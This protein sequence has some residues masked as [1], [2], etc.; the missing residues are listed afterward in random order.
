LLSICNTILNEL[1][2]TSKEKELPKR[3]LKNITVLEMAKSLEGVDPSTAYSGF[4][5]SGTAGG[6]TKLSLALGS[7]SKGKF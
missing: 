2:D 1:R 3:L 6:R 5:Y 4:A 7:K